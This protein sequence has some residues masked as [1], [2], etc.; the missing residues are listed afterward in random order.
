MRENT[1][2]SLLEGN[3]RHQADK[4]AATEGETEITYA[5]L[6]AR[7][8]SL[9]GW[10]WENG[11][12]PGDFVGIHLRKCVEE[13]VATFAV[14]RIAAVFVNINALWTIRQLCHVV[15][16]CQV[17][18]LITD[19]RRA[20]A[21]AESGLPEKLGRIVVTGSAPDHD[22]IISWASIPPHLSA[23][24]VTPAESDLATLIYTS[25]STGNPKGVMHSHLNLVQGARNIAEYLKNSAQDRVLGV[26]PMSSTYGLS[27]LTTMFLV[28]G[29]IVLQPVAIPDEIVKTVSARQVTGIAAVPPLWIQLVR[30]LE[31]VPAS[32]PSLR[33]ITTSGSALAMPFL[34]ALAE[35][36]D[37][38]EIYSM[39]G[40]T[41]GL[42]STY[43][44]P[45][46]FTEKLGSIGRAIP[47]VEVYVV[48]PERGICRPGEQGELIHRGNLICQGYWKKPEATAEIIK[49]CE[50][51]KPLIGDEKV[52]HTGDIVRM[53]ED[54]CLWFVGRN[55][56]MIK[57]GG[58]R[59]SPDEVEQI[60][61]DSGLI[62][63]VV[64]F[65]VADEMLGQLVHIA[66]TLA[67]SGRLNTEKLSSFCRRNMPG[68][69]VPRKTHVLPGPMPR[70]TTQ[71]ID[72]RRVVSMCL[73]ES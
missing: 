68:Y 4:V 42:R 58:H 54:G 52:L 56:C 27:Q 44:Q 25:G 31:Q 46:L 30:Y 34:R 55:D 7:A 13:I 71:K 9:A 18:V 65:G 26:L 29:T 16:D 19:G 40:L 38:V 22:K 8:E 70:T 62:T 3:L 49:P 72:R 67:N 61:Y 37:G 12:R 69:M 2:Y 33:Y 59:I 39:Y 50:H 20:A 10:L 21:M 36:F 43:L 28:G 60:V 11:V 1:V 32:M 64:A 41:E 5:R 17:S 63:S 35:T 47:N 24:P 14:A 73:N 15:D 66:V 45:E 57:C 51:L 23:P 53:D 48:D 6:T